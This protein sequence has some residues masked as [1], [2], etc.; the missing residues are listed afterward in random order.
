MELSPRI[1]FERLSVFSVISGG[2]SRTSR[3]CK[4]GSDGS[5]WDNTQ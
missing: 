1:Q 5:S 4:A 2:G 3:S